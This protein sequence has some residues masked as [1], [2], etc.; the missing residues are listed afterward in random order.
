M[1]QRKNAAERLRNHAEKINF[2][3]FYILKARVE[4]DLNKQLTDIEDAIRVDSK[5]WRYRKLKADV[6]ELLA[7]NNESLAANKENYQLNNKNYIVG[8]HLVRSLIRN[9]KYVDAEKVLANLHV[10]PFEGATDARRYYRETKLMLAHFAMEKG[11]YNEALN[12]VN[13]AEEWPKRLGVGKPFPDLINADLE[14]WMKYKIY[15]ALG[16]KDMSSSLLDKVTNKNINEDTY[17]NFIQQ[18]T[19]KEDRR[20]F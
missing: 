20:L 14:N 16:E 17:L 6:L 18:I 1:N 3:P 4:D 19:K 15:K 13:E 9:E 10:L 12:K 8:L 11:K 7:R 5:E 2:A